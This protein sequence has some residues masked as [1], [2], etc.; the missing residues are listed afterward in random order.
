MKKEVLF[1]AFAGDEAITSVSKPSNLSFCLAKGAFRVSLNHLKNLIPVTTRTQEQ[2]FKE[3][4][5]A[6]REELKACGI[7]GFKE[8]SGERILFE[9]GDELLRFR[10]EALSSPKRPPSSA[11]ALSKTKTQKSRNLLFLGREYC[12][13]TRRLKYFARRA[14]KFWG[15]QPLYLPCL[16]SLTDWLA[17]NFEKEAYQ[18][19]S[20]VEKRALLL[21]AARS[22]V[23]I[24]DDLERATAQKQEL[25]KKCLE[26]SPVFVASARAYKAIPENIRLIL[27]KRGFREKTLKSRATRDLTFAVLALIVVLAALGGHYEWLITLMAARLLL[28]QPL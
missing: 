18:G 11:R 28:R 15:L 22:R 2:R 1:L 7:I 16:Y 13:K 6:A 10:E 19:L 27:E 3:R 20:Q 25:V 8:L 4:F 24:V 5:P 12:G 17:L 26:E 21:S 9:P 23:V 14:E